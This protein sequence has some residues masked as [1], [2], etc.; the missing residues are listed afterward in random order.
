MLLLTIL[1][2][3]TAASKDIKRGAKTDAA[4]P[5]PRMLQL[6]DYSRTLNIFAKV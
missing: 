6:L 4:P 5:P 3:T 1:T 2:V